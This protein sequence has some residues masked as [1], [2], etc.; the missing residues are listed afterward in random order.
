MSIARREVTHLPS[1][2]LAGIPEEARLWT[3]DAFMHTES[4]IAAPDEQVG[5]RTAL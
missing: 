1:S 3:H 2:F 4:G 5:V